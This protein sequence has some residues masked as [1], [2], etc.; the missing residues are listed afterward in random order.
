MSRSHGDLLV[1]DSTMVPPVHIGLGW[2]CTTIILFV[3]MAIWLVG[4]IT[5]LQLANWHIC[6]KNGPR[7]DLPVVLLFGFAC[8]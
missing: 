3:P 4:N 5:A 1:N 7:G 8:R 6:P 2:E